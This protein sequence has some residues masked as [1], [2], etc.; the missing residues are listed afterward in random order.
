[1]SFEELIKA[2]L[3][4]LKAYSDDA[5]CNGCESIGVMYIT[6]RQSL[7]N[8]IKDLNI[9]IVVNEILSANS[10]VSVGEIIGLKDYNFNT[11]KKLSLEF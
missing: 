6:W 4:K 10:S 9:K 3:N 1:M 7:I 5:F 2:T 11:L 8:A